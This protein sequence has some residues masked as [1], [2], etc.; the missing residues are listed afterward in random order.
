MC[1]GEGIPKDSGRLHRRLIGRINSILRRTNACNAIRESRNDPWETRKDRS[2]NKSS[3]E[4]IRARIHTPP[5]DSL[6]FSTVFDFAGGELRGPYFDGPRQ[7]LT[8]DRGAFREAWRDRR[9]GDAT[10]RIRTRSK[11]SRRITTV[12]F[13]QIRK[14]HGLIGNYQSQTTVYY[15]ARHARVPLVTF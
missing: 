15:V 2:S 6:A 10:R 4:F 14:D 9:F 7:R 8:S 11:R 3:E 1:G 12:Y 13:R 5:C